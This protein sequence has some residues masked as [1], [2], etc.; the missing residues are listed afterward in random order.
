AAGDCGRLRRRPGILADQLPEAA[1]GVGG[2]ARAVVV[3]RYVDLAGLLRER[4]GAAGQ[5]I[6]LVVRVDPAEALGHRLAL[7][8]ALGVAAVA[9]QVGDVAPGDGVDRR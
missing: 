1:R 2:V 3:E 9:A 6:E 4:L 7:Q 8:V 5:L